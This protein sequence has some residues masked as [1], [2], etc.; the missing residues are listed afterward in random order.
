MPASPLCLPRRHEGHEVPQLVGVGFV[1]FVSNG[2]AASPPVRCPISLPFAQEEYGQSGRLARNL[3]TVL[4][5]GCVCRYYFHA[6]PWVPC[7]SWPSPSGRAPRRQRPPTLPLSGTSRP[8][9]PGSMAGRSTASQRK[10]GLP[11]ARAV[12]H[13]VRP[14]GHRPAADP[15]FGRRRPSSLPAR[16]VPP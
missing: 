10:L 8:A 9:N 7:L 15:A 11:T 3:E 16:R 6:S 1:S 12:V 14:A 4:L 2:A 5:E 13:L